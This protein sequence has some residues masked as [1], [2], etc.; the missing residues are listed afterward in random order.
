VKK[1]HLKSGE[2]KDT[3]P[4]LKRKL[5]KGVSILGKGKGK[6]NRSGKNA[7][8]P[9]ASDEEISELSPLEVAQAR[10]TRVKE[11]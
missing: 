2:G 1:G 7:R 3:H 8:P 9:G 6:G 11:H 10:T 5:E 4:L